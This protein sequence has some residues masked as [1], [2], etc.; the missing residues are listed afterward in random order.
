MQR[1]A[2]REGISGME[3]PSGAG[4]DAQQIAALCPVAMVFIRSRD[5]RS[6]TPEEYSSPQDIEAGVRVLAGTLYELGYAEE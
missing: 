3:M 4:H 5:G 1:A 2:R 6:H